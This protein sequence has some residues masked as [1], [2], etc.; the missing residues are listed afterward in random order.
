MIASI[1]GS[2]ARA[3]RR[4]AAERDVAALATGFALALITYLTTGLFLHFAYIRYFWLFAA[5]AAAMGMVVDPERT[6]TRH[7]ARARGRHDEVHTEVQ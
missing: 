5:L 6:V 3:R 2:L 4:L 7:T 1:L